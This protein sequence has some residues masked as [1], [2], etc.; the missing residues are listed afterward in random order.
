MAFKKQK[1]PRISPGRFFIG[2]SF[3]INVAQIGRLTRRIGLFHPAGREEHSRAP[4]LSRYNAR[5][6]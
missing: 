6:V 1:T 4:R 3:R 2:A 5:L